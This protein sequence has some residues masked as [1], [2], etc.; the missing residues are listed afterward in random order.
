MLRRNR[1]YIPHP[2]RMKFAK[3]RILL[4]GVHLV[5]G[6][7]E[8]LAGAR[9]QSS[10][11]A[12]GSRD[13]GS[14]I[15]H[16]DDGRR[17]FERDLGLTEDLRR[18]EIFVVGNDTARIH[19][20]KLVPAPFGLAIQA[21]ASDAGLVPNNGTT[22]SGQMVEQS[23]FADVRA[24]DNGDEWGWLLFAQSIFIIKVEDDSQ[25]PNDRVVTGL[26]PVPARRSPATT[27]KRRLRTN[28][29]L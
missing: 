6:E 26:C 4:V 13:L 18:Y 28:P 24:S 20:A 15:H 12:V 9:Q 16:H 7:K 5:D 1:K 23:R 3:Q 29:I 11:L 17:L 27:H 8:R 19:D 21:V 22:R 14:R 10:Q 25:E 2:K